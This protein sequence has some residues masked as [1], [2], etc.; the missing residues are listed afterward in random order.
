M[1]HASWSRL[2]PCS[3]WQTTAHQPKSRA[4]HDASRNKHMGTDKDKHNDNTIQ[5]LTC[6][7]RQK[8]NVSISAPITTSSNDYRDSASPTTAPTKTGATTRT[9][10][11]PAPIAIAPSR[12]LRPASI[13]HNISEQRMQHENRNPQTNT[14]YHGLQQPLTNTNTQAQ[15]HPQ[16]TVDAKRPPAS[17]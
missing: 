11:T 13:P 12:E 4:D 5:N 3:S 14:R 7:P 2:A 16:T 8:S 1:R 15:T 17:P 6:Q 10:V 9:T